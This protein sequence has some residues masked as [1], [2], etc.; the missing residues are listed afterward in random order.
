MQDNSPIDDR[1]LLDRPVH[2][3]FTSKARDVFAAASGDPDNSTALAAWAQ[4]AHDDPDMTT[5][6]QVIVA[7]DGTI[8]GQA[9][10]VP[11]RVG[12]AYVRAVTHDRDRDLIGREVGL[13]VGSLA[14]SHGAR[15]IVVT[16]SQVCAG[17]GDK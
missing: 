8:L 16:Y 12:A 17:Q 15:A 5:R 9:R 7:A 10:Y 4:A 1:L 2:A 11:G 6:D 13:A 3:Y 14:R